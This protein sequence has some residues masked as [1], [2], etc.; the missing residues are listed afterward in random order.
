MKR[1]ICT[2]CHRTLAL[3]SFN[4]NRCKKDGFATLCRE[5]NRKH[6][7]AYYRRWR[8]KHKTV[9]AE[10][11]A[12]MVRENHKK[13]LEYLLSHPCVDCGERDPIVLEFDHVRGK[14]KRNVNGLFR[15]YSWEVV[16]R[17][18]RKCEV[19]CANCHRRKTMRGCYKDIR[20]GSLAS[21]SSRLLSGRSRVQVPS[22]P[23]RR[24]EAV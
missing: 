4:R 7:R 5:C 10:R 15:G 17:E 22:D 18:I 3:S 8:K 19:R 2:V 23:P 6:S 24:K 21:E 12:R 9:V 11:N 13:I 1:K 14:K 16:E 20:V